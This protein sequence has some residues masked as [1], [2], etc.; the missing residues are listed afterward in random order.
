MKSTKTT[1]HDA[2]VAFFHANG[3]YSYD[4]ATQTP[5]EGRRASA[6][7]LADAEALWLEVVRANL[8]RFEV[9]PD[10]MGTLDY[11]VPCCGMVLLDNEDQSLA[12]LWG[13]DD[14]SP[15]YQRVV[16]AELVLD[17]ADALKAMLEAA[18]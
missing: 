17:C 13:I 10:P 14:S 2:A 9:R 15:R 16:R 6:L 12:S 7:A 18:Q 3:C 11:E 1:A 4:P 8:A 5:E